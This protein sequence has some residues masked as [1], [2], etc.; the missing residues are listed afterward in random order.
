M[1]KASLFDN[2]IGIQ[3][4]AH[5]QEGTRAL[6]KYGA[7]YFLSIL[8]SQQLFKTQD[9]IHELQEIS[10]SLGSLSK[11]SRT[12][13]SLMD[14]LV[15]RGYVNEIQ[16]DLYEMSDSS[17]VVSES[18]LS[19]QFNEIE[20]L[21]PEAAE[22]A[23]HMK[24]ALES[25][26]GV[27]SGKKSFLPVMFPGGSF[28][29]IEQIY[30]LSPD[31][32]YFN[33]MVAIVV[34]NYINTNEK[35]GDPISIVELGAGI[36]STAEYVLPILQEAKSSVEY[37][38]TDISKAFIN[39]GEKKYASNYDFISFRLL[40]LDTAPIDQDFK[41]YDIVIAAN[42]LHATK[43]II[44]TL[45]HV[46]SLLKPGGLLIANDGVSRKDFSTLAYG[47]LDGWWAFE[48]NEWRIP[49]TPFISLES[50]K[51][52][53]SQSSFHHIYSLNET[54]RPEIELF[55]DVII[56]NKS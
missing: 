43:N 2:E 4:I 18:Q 22:N 36:G 23:M 51:K 33:K 9:D 42:I 12:L 46:N 49:G 13:K 54:T 16:L 6:E 39:Y 26:P 14:I 7:L 47:L 19:K 34:E 56:A 10:N 29:I 27:I 38:Y 15:R 28:K 45:K 32:A 3:N 52:V 48:D 24:R 35:Q 53:L 5:F 1:N 8:Q 25:Y 31:S 21:Y 50:W 40:D 55:Q 44:T 11:Y 37:I 30:R 17:F 20:T 41:Q